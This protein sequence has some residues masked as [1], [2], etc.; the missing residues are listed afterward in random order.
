MDQTDDESGPYQGKGTKVAATANWDLI[1]SDALQGRRIYLPRFVFEHPDGST[2]DTPRPHNYE[3][4]R[5][6]LDQP[7]EDLGD[8]TAEIWHRFKVT[9]ANCRSRQDIIETV[10]PVFLRS[11]PKSEICQQL[12]ERC[13]GLEPVCEGFSEL[14]SD[15]MDGEH[16]HFL[17]PMLR[18]ELGK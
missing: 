6:A 12:Y 15:M 11:N 1:L 14:R 3:D 18:D 7:R 10:L 5:T 4:T 17:H 13:I 8:L 16:L 2:E 9:D